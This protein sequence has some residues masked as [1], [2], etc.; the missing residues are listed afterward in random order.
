M[1]NSDD[2]TSTSPG[3]QI[4]IGWYQPE[5]LRIT[6][7]MPAAG[8]VLPPDV[9]IPKLLMVGAWL[10]RLGFTV[11]RRVLVDAAPG[12][13]TLVLDETPVTVPYR[14]RKHT[15]KKKRSRATG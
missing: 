5:T 6:N 1:H 8:N 15:P 7:F 11:G 14:Y 4:G 9:S 2:G 3:H 10:E 13:I 12:C